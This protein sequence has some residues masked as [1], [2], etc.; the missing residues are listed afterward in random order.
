M[1]AVLNPIT[2]QATLFGGDEEVDVFFTDLDEW[3]EVTI[4][5]MRIFVHFD[6]EPRNNFGSQKDWLH[7]MLQAYTLESV[8]QQYDNQLINNIKLEL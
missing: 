2:R 6:Y 4:N 1:R 5:E 7:Y 3:T 8:N